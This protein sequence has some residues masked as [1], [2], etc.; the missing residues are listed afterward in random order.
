MLLLA[1]DSPCEVLL[2]E[3]G[4]ADIAASWLEKA[5]HED[6]YNNSDDP[7]HYLSLLYILFSVSRSASLNFSDSREANSSL[8]LTSLET[9]SSRI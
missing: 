7:F 3:T 1:V 9:A 2:L 8:L 6:E 4:T 5:N